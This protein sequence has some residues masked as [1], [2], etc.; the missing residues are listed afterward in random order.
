MAD[1]PSTVHYRSVSQYRQY[2]GECPH[3]Y[4]L[5]RVVKAWQRPAA[6]LPQGTA[7]HAAI[8]A[9]ERSGRLLTVDQAQ[10]VFRE[11][12]A[13]EVNASTAHTPNLSFWSRSGPYDGERD[14]ERRYGLG[15]EQV[16]RY[17]SYCEGAGAEETPWVTPD[18]TLAVELGFVIEL[19]GVWVRG[20]IDNV[21][22]HPRRTSLTVRDAKTGRL[23]G[24][25]FQLGVYALAIEEVYDHE[26]RFGDYWMAQSGK[27][28]FP[29]DL[30]EWTKPRLTEMFGELD[31]A[32]T[33]EDWTPRPDPASC[34]RCSVSSACPFAV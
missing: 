4:Y 30:K 15:L 23:P 24:D 10:D 32:I 34:G 19:G 26:A 9:Y 3:A 18:G 29:Y 25:P 22:K 20:Y 5:S 12:Y 2:F 6:W 1:A 28:T 31:A 27:A 21:Y 11:S 8:E 33:A 7:V 17:L 16:A 13:A 14:I